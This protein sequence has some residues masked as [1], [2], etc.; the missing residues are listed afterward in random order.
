MALNP[1]DKI[2]K[3]K[4]LNYDD[5]TQEEK[6]LYIKAG[7]GTRGVTLSD[8]KEHLDEMLYE[9]LL[10][11]CDTPDTP[12]NQDKNKYQ[13]ARIKNYALLQAFMEVPDKVAKALEKELEN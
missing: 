9:L 2:L 5:L 7:R 8:L 1:Y 6:E 4:G 11:H 10:E 3:D 12:E 13:K